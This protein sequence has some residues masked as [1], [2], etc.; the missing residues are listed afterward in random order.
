VFVDDTGRRRRL[1]RRLCRLIPVCCLFYFALL[2]AGFAGDARLSNPD[3]PML[4]VGSGSAGILGDSPPGVAPPGGGTRQ[5]ARP[6]TTTPTFNAAKSPLDITAPPTAPAGPP[7]PQS[8]AAVTGATTSAVPGPPP[9]TLM[10]T[11]GPDAGR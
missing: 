5:A 2:G 7:M 10:T 3:L 8:V 11:T 6:V 1:G 9:P 4:V